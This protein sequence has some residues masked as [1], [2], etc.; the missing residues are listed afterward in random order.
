MVLDNFEHL[1]SGAPLVTRLLEAAPRLKALVRR[2]AVFSGGCT[3]AAAEAVCGHGGVDAL[4]GLGS[5]VD[6]SL[7]R[8]REQRG[9][10]LRFRMLEVVRE[11]AFERLEAA[12]EAEAAR[13]RH[14][15]HFLEL[16]L[17]GDPNSRGNEAS[18]IAGLGRDH[19]NLA[20]ALAVLLEREPRDGVKLMVT[21]RRYWSSRP[22]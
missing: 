13:L 5:L 19:E 17:E 15:R 4:E 7:L 11:F 16:A 12:G 10:E 9:G 3:L 22:R 6:K 14:A 20:S 8:Q 1:L 21:C 2:L 18:W